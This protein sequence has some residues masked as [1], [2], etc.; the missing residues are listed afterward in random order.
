MRVTQQTCRIL[1]LSDDTAELL[2]LRRQLHRQELRHDIV[3]L[4]SRNDAVEA[5]SA[6]PFDIVFL[7]SRFSMDAAGVSSDLRRI[8][9]HSVLISLYDRNTPPAG[10]NGNGQRPHDLFCDGGDPDDIARASDVAMTLVSQARAMEEREIGK[11]AID[12]LN[13]PVLLVDRE[14]RLLLRNRQSRACEAEGMYIRVEEGGQVVPGALESGRTLVE[15]IKH[16][17]TSPHEDGDVGILRGVSP[18]RT[19][20]YVAFL[21]TH[22]STEWNRA[23]FS[24]AF[25]SEEIARTDA[26]SIRAALK[27]SVSESRLVQGLIEHGGLQDGAEAAGLSINTARSYLRTIFAKTGVRSQVELVRLV[28]KTAVPLWVGVSDRPS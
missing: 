24:L 28:M 13:L 6:N 16:F 8:S 5:H 12:R 7:G 10:A 9:R 27:L 20:P 21:A 1:L 14:A 11:K 3:L 2:R 26:A 19:S 15:E 23:F 25:T 18:D 17:E 22:P 4:L